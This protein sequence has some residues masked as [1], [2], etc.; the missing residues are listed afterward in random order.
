MATEIHPLRVLS[1]NGY[2]TSDGQ[3][4]AET[5]RHRDLMFDLIK[6]LEMFFVLQPD[7]YVSGNLLL[8]YERG[9]KRRHLSPDVFVCRGVPKGERLNFLV[10][11]EGKGPD[12]VI[13]LTSSSTRH[14]DVVRKFRLYRDVLKVREYFLFDPYGDHL[15]PQLQGYRLHRGDYVPIRPVHGRLPSKVLGLHLVAHE[16]DLRLCDSV[17]GN[18]LLNPAERIENAEADLH[19]AEAALLH[20]EAENQQLR[21]ALDRLRAERNGGR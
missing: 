14:K 1:S 21:Q 5:D 11:E 2:P 13:E 10:W 7:V 16:E 3:P 15:D 12:L 9:N 6:I 4:M 17:T 8:F 18:W 20:S 19:L